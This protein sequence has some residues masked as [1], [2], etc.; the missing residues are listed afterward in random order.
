MF[1]LNMSM[2]L[3]VFQNLAEPLTKKRLSFAKYTI[4]A[5]AVTGR[6]IAQYSDETL[7][8]IRPSLLR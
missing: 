7:R 1:A 2:L 5:I 4:A 6:R 8:F 3:N